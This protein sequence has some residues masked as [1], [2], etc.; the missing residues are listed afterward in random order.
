MFLTLDL[1]EEEEGPEA[2]AEEEEWCLVH[3]QWLKRLA[4]TLAKVMVS[5]KSIKI[6]F[7]NNKDAARNAAYQGID[8]FDAKLIENRLLE[9]TK[10]RY[11]W[12][13]YLSLTDKEKIFTASDFQR[14]D[15][16]AVRAR[17][18]GEYVSQTEKGDTERRKALK[19]LMEDLAEAIM[20][21][22]STEAWLATSLWLF[23]GAA[24][25]LQ[26]QESPTEDEVIMAS[27]LLR[28]YAAA[29]LLVESVI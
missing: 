14:P 27:G 6:P 22:K 29:V 24:E 11:A 15:D 7:T 28:N 1:T 18:I 3:D 23:W 26:L 20:E 12:V 25:V 5:H 17:K 9:E 21:C 2:E 13:M 8:K 16:L 19:A 10:C 4:S